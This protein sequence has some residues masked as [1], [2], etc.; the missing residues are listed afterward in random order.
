MIQDVC[1]KIS[2]R[3]AGPLQAKTWTIGRCSLRLVLKEESWT[4]LLSY[5]SLPSGLTSKQAREKR[6]AVTKAEQ[7]QEIFRDFCVLHPQH[8]VCK[9]KYRDDGIILPFGSSREDFT[10]PN[11]FV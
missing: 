4:A 5:F 6:I 7:Q 11:P 1:A 3:R 10:V 2:E 8:C 9:E